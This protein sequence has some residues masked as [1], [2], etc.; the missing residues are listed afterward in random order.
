M[1][2]S[3]A[4]LI[5]RR[6]RYT[7]GL[8]QALTC[9]LVAFMVA[10]CAGLSGPD[11]K[12]PDAPTKAQWSHDTRLQTSAADT[13]QPDWWKNFN[14]PYLDDLIARAIEANID[15]KVLAARIQVAEA[16]VGQAKAGTQS[17]V[18]GAMGGNFQKSKG[19]DLT[20][21][22]S[23]SSSLNWEI[24]IWGKLR[25]GVEASKA[26]YQ[27][28]EAD[29]R[30]GYLK[31]VSDVSNAYFQIRKFDEQIDQQ[32]L[33]L[34]KNR[35][36][37]VIYESMQA[38][39]LVPETQVLQQRAEVAGLKNGLLELSRQRKVTE[40]ALATLLGVPAGDFRVSPGRL[41]E[42]VH[43]M[44]VPA[45]LPSDLLARRPDIVAAEYRVLEAHNLTAKARL[46]K[47]PSV[48]LTARGGNSSLALSSLLSTWT[49]GLLPTVDF[50][51]FD[52]NVGARIKVNEAQTRVAEEEYRR[53][54][55]KAFEEVENALTNLASH[56][57]QKYEL[58]S[59]RDQ[60]RVVSEQVQA[61]LREGIV[62]QLEVFEAERSLLG[63]E[64]ELLENHQQILS[65][66]VALYKAL[67]GG[68]PPQVVT[69]SR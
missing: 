48:S 14:D 8:W 2:D 19:Q 67:G 60:L 33:A 39:G 31:L 63:A 38:E 43:L 52:P 5:W 62:S 16:G 65:D 61:Q 1:S 64:Q 27:A 56:R 24:D 21:S 23:T 17:V 32:G 11:Y 49:L 37:L 55:I 3:F 40:N 53:T 29:W 66:T 4:N 22:Y 69:R 20:K 6:L 44:D 13:I 58:E 35:R 59:R 9:A 15:I 25:K 45:G 68:W 36:I 7:A 46:A 50:P 42:R 10:A 41:R 18:E 12:R 47:L 30:A 51:I 26:G 34:D 28:T 57:S 54:V